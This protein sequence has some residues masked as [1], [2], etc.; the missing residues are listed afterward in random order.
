[1]GFSGQRANYQCRRSGADDA[2]IADHQDLYRLGWDFV[3]EQ[4]QGTA[5]IWRM[6]RESVDYPRLAS[7]YAG[8]GDVDCPAGVGLGDLLYL[9]D[10]WLAEGDVCCGAADIN[11]DGRVGM[12]DY[13]VLA[14][15]WHAGMPLFLDSLIA[16]W[17]M[18]DHAAGNTVLDNSGNNL[19]GTSQQNTAALT[20][21][22]KMDAALS[23]NGTT[24]WIDCGT[25]AMLL[26]DA[27]TLC[28]WVKCSDTTTPMLISF[29]GNYPSIKLQNNTRGKPLIHLGQ[30]NYRYFSTSAWMT[31][32]DGQWHHVAVS[33]PGKGQTDIGQVVMYVDSTA[34]IGDAAV[35]TGP[36]AGKSHVYLG[37]NPS[38]PVQ[39]F[40][41]AMD[42][43]M[44][45]NR[46]LEE[47]EIRLVMNWTP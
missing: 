43:V 41:G 20:T 4:T 3:G 11:G 35:A 9:V 38:V 30:Y 8:N 44:L 18:D 47:A 2:R 15:N 16:Y 21:A 31:L 42:E 12:D 40:G 22:G 46:V 34:V 39:R 19:V 27:W 36:Q 5:D 7:E 23:F 29:G 1:V 24:D 25:N 37:A 10:R 33:V 32:K 6:C 45:F 13:A 14:G 26:P 17:A 28:A